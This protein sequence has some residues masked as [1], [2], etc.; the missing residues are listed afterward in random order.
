MSRPGPHIQTPEATVS[1]PARRADTTI[2]SA[3]GVTVAALA[4]IAGAISYSHM[5]EL[6]VAHGRAPR[7]RSR[8]AP[9]PPGPTG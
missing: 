4:G 6:A 1:A 5:R 3:A 7:C 2:R 9:W 8:A